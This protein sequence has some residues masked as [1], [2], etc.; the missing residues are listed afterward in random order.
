[1]GVCAKWKTSNNICFLV[2]VYSPCDFDGKKEL[3]KDLLLCKRCFGGGVWCVAGDFN[4]IFAVEERRGASRLYGG[5]EISGFNQ[6]ISDMELIDVSVLGKKYTWFSGDGSAKSRLDRFLLTEE[7]ISTW[8]VAAQWVGNRDI[9]DHC[10]IWLDC[11]SYDCG[12]KPF[13]FNNCWLQHKDFKDFVDK[14]WRSFNVD[15]WRMYVFKEK[16]K[17]LRE[18]L[19][20]WNKE[21][22]GFLDLNIKNIVNE[23]NA[24][25][26]LVGGSNCQEVERRKELSSLFWHQVQAKE[27]LIKQKARCRW[28]AEGD[29]N[30]RY[31]YACV[32]GR[33]RRNQIVALKKG[34]AWIEGVEDIKNEVKSH[35]QNFF[36]KPME[37]RRSWMVSILIKFQIWIMKI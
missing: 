23:I 2:N 35:F 3:W 37:C 24:L 31:F 34:E 33:R 15:G 8:K 7:A 16:L 18:K 21:V 6:F 29:A 1:M 26:E 4:A 32:R 36:S 10:P 20:V 27:S 13:R 19:R 22:F 5:R 9:S 12:P 14:S 30:T 17:M 28:I 25:D 11:S